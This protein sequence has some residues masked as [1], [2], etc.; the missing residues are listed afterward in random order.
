MRA[1]VMNA[2]GAPDVLHVTDVPDAPE[3]GPG[4]VRVSVRAAAINPVDCQV[5]SG[6]KGGEPTVPLPMT[7]G[8]DLSGTVD[9]VGP[10]VTRFRAGNPVV[11]M[12]AQAATGLGTWAQ[13]VTLGQD[14]LAPAPE[15]V[16]LADAAALPLG[17]LSTYQAL[18]RLNLPAGG[19]LL[20]TGGAGALGGFA[21]QLARERG[22]Y[23][24]ALVRPSDRDLARELGAGE[25][26]TELPDAPR[27]DALFETAGIASA[28]G[29]VR[30]GGQAV[31]VVPTAV[32]AAE[33]GIHPV[34]SFVDQDGA[35]LERLVALVDGRTLTVRIAHAFPFDAAAEAVALF[36]AGGVRGKVLLIP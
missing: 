3:P 22:W 25:V 10:D 29:A 18:D 15:S 2:F 17:A 27:Y 13:R 31:T 8:W 12:S 11:G 24:A 21:L 9:A 35:L 34:V 32:P 23:T 4:Q 30:D 6:S 36:E 1:V 7:L 14:L 26:L 16:P 28:I 19:S 33:R 20:V 5:R